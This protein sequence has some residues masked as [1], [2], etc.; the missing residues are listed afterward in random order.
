VPKFNGSIGRLI[1]LPPANSI[2]L[3]TAGKLDLD[4]QYPQF[5]GKVR[6]RP[7]VCTTVTIRGLRRIAK[8]A[9]REEWLM[10]NPPNHFSPMNA[11]R[12]AKDVDRDG[13]VVD[14]H[15]PR[16]C[17]TPAFVSPIADSFFRSEK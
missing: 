13:S 9:C 17:G 3:K 14:G 1:D 10:D 4:Q 8:S 12:C 2:L 7:G 15:D 5:R 16:R 11:P 6:L